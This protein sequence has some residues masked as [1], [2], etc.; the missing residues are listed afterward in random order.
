M[1]ITLFRCIDGEFYD[2]HAPLRTVSVRED[3]DKKSVIQSIRDCIGN[4]S[5]PLILR[6]QAIAFTK[7]L[8]VSISFDTTVE[9]FSVPA[10][11]AIV[12]DTMV[13]ALKRKG[14]E[15]LAPQ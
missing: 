14:V 3:Y 15:I 10:Y 12:G 9:G 4:Y 13:E 7:A 6:F 5:G 1:T 8:A 2:R 11:A